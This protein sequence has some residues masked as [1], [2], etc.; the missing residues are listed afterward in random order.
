MRV[1]KMQGVTQDEVEEVVVLVETEAEK[2]GVKMLEVFEWVEALKLKEGF[3]DFQGLGKCGHDSDSD[4]CRC[5]PLSL[6]SRLTT[7]EEEEEEEEMKIE[8]TLFQ[9]CVLV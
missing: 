5:C 6:I 2:V 8:V 9:V 7:L 3:L 1:T 4:S